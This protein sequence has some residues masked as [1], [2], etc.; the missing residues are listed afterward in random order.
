MDQGTLS[1]VRRGD[2][3]AL[4]A[5]VSAHHR[6]LRGFVAVL[7]VPPDSVDDVSQEVFLRGFRLLDRVDDLRQFDRFLRGIARN[8]VKEHFRARLPAHRSF[9]ELVDRLSAREPADRSDGSEVM[10][11]LRRCLERLTPRSRRMLDL[12]YAEEKSPDEIASE[13]GLKGG[14]VRVL[15]VRIRE[16]LVKCMRPEARAGEAMP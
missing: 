12:R 9:E 10:E 1:A 15:L 3:E 6:R 2:P 11:A 8:V 7:G 16:A 5:L 14:S 13:L 4:G